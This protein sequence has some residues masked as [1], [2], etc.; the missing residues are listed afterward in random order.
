MNNIKYRVWNG[1][2]NVRIVLDGAEYLLQA[3]RTLYFPIYFPAIALFFS[4]VLGKDIRNVWLQYEDVPLKWNLPVGVLYDLFY[5]PTHLDGGHW[6]LHL[7][8]GDMFPKDDIIPFHSN[9]SSV[10]YQSLLHEM[11][12]NHLKQS[13]YV[14]SGNSRAVMNLSENDTKS[15][16]AAVLL[17]DYGVYA[18]IM[19]KVSPKT[20]QRVPI[21]LYL[22]GSSSLIQAPVFPTSNLGKQTTLR[23]VLR[24]WLPEML[25]S[26]KATAYIQG[27]NVDVLYDAP[28]IDVWNSFCHLDNFLYI[29]VAVS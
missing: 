7:R 2:V 13:C 14:M 10:G 17:H 11:F 22:A 19:K 16:W 4:A 20:L 23:D 25:E 21:K 6:T 3:H 8:Y 12:I 9:G 1:S 24:Q 28:I 15:L 26:N 5:L 18:S 29:V 27:I